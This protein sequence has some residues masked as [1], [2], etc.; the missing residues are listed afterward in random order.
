MPYYRSADIDVYLSTTDLNATASRDGIVFD[1]KTSTGI[2]AHNG[3]TLA[4]GERLKERLVKDDDGM[5]RMRF[6]G[7]DKDLP[8][9]LAYVDSGQSCP[10]TV[11][12]ASPETPVPDGAGNVCETWY[13]FLLQG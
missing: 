1:R 9:L 5:G 6:I 3:Q 4:S 2:I 13:P 8:L 10:V 12:N 7:P 11:Q